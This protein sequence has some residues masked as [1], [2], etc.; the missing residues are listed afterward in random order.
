MFVAVCLSPGTCLRCVTRRMAIYLWT[1]DTSIIF[2]VG[3]P[4]NHRVPSVPPVNWDHDIGYCR[5]H[6]VSVCLYIA[7]IACG[8]VSLYI[9]T[10][11]F[12]FCTL[13]LSAVATVT[14]IKI[15]YDAKAPQFAIFGTHIICVFYS[16]F[17]KH[18]GTYSKFSL[19]ISR[20]KFGRVFMEYFKIK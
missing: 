2:Q 11:Y 10:L 4:L 12:F 16:T 3:P 5:T 6:N 1:E 13:A 9:N 8:S 18:F 14:N 20:R 19:Y 17:K 7:Y 15:R